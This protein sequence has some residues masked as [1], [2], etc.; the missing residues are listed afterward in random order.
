MIF[1]G[2]RVAGF[3]RANLLPV[4]RR[5]QLRGVETE[6]QIGLLLHAR[7]SG[8]GTSNVHRANLVALVLCEGDRHERRSPAG[9]VLARVEAFGPKAVGYHLDFAAR[10]QRVSAARLHADAIRPTV[11]V[12]AGRPGLYRKSDQIAALIAANRPARHD[13]LRDV[14][15]AG[16]VILAA[17][18]RYDRIG[19]GDHRFGFEVLPPQHEMPGA[20][21]GVLVFQPH[22]VT[23]MRVQSRCNIGGPFACGRYQSAVTV[24][25]GAESATAFSARC[26]SWGNSLPRFAAR[27]RIPA[28]AFAVK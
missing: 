15:F 4:L 22:L 1:R 8:Q 14:G 25:I 11:R 16:L 13:R 28:Q 9:A 23:K 7:L 27:R 3:V 19:L 10:L 21:Q 24:E 17:V 26:K 2:K 20:V 6:S 18:H 5:G 12:L